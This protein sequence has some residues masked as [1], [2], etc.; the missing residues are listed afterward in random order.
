MPS[1]ESN[2]TLNMWYSFNYGPVHFISLDTETAFPGAPEEHAY[3]LPCGGFGD[4][5]SWLEADLQAANSNRALR[6]WIFVASHHPMYNGGS[7]NRP[8][9][10]AIEVGPCTR[11]SRPR[12]PG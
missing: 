12:N 4:M 10:A 7:V 3:V 6:P 1:P 8:F 2:G 9:Q 11:L 5:L